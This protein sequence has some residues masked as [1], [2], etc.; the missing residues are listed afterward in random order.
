[1]LVSNVVG[2]ALPAAVDAGLELSV[3]AESAQRT[4][5]PGAK[6]AAAR[7]LSKPLTA[8]ANAAQTGAFVLN[9]AELHAAAAF[10]PG[11]YDINLNAIASFKGKKPGVFWP[12][13][14]RCSAN[15]T[16]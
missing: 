8:R 6:E 7:A 11:F 16:F 12:L 4:L 14:I 2:E 3:V 9:L 10:E 15:H 5:Q 1:M 13:F